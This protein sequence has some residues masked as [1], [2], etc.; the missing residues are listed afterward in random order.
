M[1]VDDREPSVWLQDVA[2]CAGQTRTITDTVEG[3]RQED[4]VN[5]SARETGKLIGIA[6]EKLAVARAAF[7][8]ARA[9]D[10]QQ[11]LINVDSG[12]V[13]GDLCN[14]QGEPAVP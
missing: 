8:K 1:P 12:D 9:S 4:E 6:R 3:I 5:R 10:F 7:F 14:R 11:S 13:P 2:D